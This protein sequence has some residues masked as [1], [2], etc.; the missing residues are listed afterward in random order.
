M[1]NMRNNKKLEKHVELKRKQDKANLKSLNTFFKGLHEEQ[2]KRDKEPSPFVQILN[3]L[4]VF[5]NNMTRLEYERSLKDKEYRMEKYKEAYAN[6][7]RD[8]ED[9]NSTF[10]WI[11]N[12]YIRLKIYRIK[13]LWARLNVFMRGEIT[14]QELRTQKWRDLIKNRLLLFTYLK[15]VRYLLYVRYVNHIK[16]KFLT[17]FPKTVR[18]FFFLNLKYIKP[19]LSRVNKFLNRHVV[20]HLK[21]WSSEEFS[22]GWLFSTNHKRI[23]ILYL[24]LGAFN[25]ILAILFSVFIRIELSSPGDLVLFGNPSF[26]NMCVTMHGILMLFV[27]VMPILFGGFG[28][29]FLP[30]LVGAPD[31][32]FP[33]LNNLSFWLVPS[34]ILL[35][36]HAIFVDGG[37]GTG[38]TI[39]PPLSSLIGHGSASVDFIIL[40]FH[41][42]GMSSIIGSINFVCTIFFFKNEAFYLTELPLFIWTVI[43]TSFLLIF[44]L[45]V[46]ASAITLLFFDRNFNTSFYDPIGGGDVVLFQHLFWFFGHPEVYILILPGFGVVSH[47]IS[48]YSQKPIFGYVP[49]ISA[50]ILIGFIGFI[51]WAFYKNI[52]CLLL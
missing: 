47:I 40:S 14:P 32:C 8:R 12:T 23:G 31:M 5:P 2:K 13:I 25:G 18:V 42:I 24:I 26:Y 20:E 44:A 38:W 41:I 45:P 7:Y 36:V 37:P 43:V 22:N 4:P 39:Y 27:V 29:Y 6:G 51:V 21:Y 3:E 9:F 17:S 28:N 52:L 11:L 10:M 49:M 15:R 34:G 50:S 33:R 30:I 48:T 19:L 1:D 35:S 16:V 46:L